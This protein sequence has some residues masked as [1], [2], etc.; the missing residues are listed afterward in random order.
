MLRAA[1]AAAAAGVVH[2]AVAYAAYLAAGLA[3]RGSMDLPLA[4]DA[5]RT[6]AACAAAVAA[7]WA[8]LALA[9]TSGRGVWSR[10]LRQLASRAASRPGAVFAAASAA[11]ALSAAAALASVPCAQYQGHPACSGI[12]WLLPAA[13]LCAL[14]WPL[15]AGRPAPDPGRSPPGI[16]DALVAAVLAAL[17]PRP[18]RRPRPGRRRSPPPAGPPQAWIAPTGLNTGA[19]KGLQRVFWV[20]PGYSR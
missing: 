5:A 3:G 12:L 2:L 7:G 20:T 17:A 10:A 18:W 11:S 9:D 15:S 14:A 8:A 13:A 1:G 16:R 19:A 6:A 4:L